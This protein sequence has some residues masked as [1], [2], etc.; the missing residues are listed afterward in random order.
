MAQDPEVDE[1]GIPVMKQPKPKQPKQEVDEFGIPV[2]KQPKQEVDEFGIPL[3][4]KG[5]GSSFIKSDSDGQFIL[6]EKST[7]GNSWFID[8][9][10][11]KEKPEFKEKESPVKFTPAFR[12]RIPERDATSVKKSIDLAEGDITTTPE[13]KMRR[14]AIQRADKANKAIQNNTK[15]ELDRKNVKYKVGDATYEKKKQELQKKYES[16]DLKVILGYDGEPQLARELTYAEEGLRGLDSFFNSVA[17]LFGTNKHKSTRSM[18]EDELINYYNENREKRER[19]GYTYSSQVGSA[20]QSVIAIAPYMFL[21]RGLGNI[22]R[23]SGTAL[24]SRIISNPLLRTGS[25]AEIGE[26]V[27]AGAG[28]SYLF[29]KSAGDAEREKRYNE[30]VDE[31]TAAGRTDLDNIY[32]EAI[33]KAKIQAED[34]EVIAAGTGLLQSIPMNNILKSTDF[35][36]NKKNFGRILLSEI[37]TVNRDAPLQ[38]GSMA[39]QN[40]LTEKSAES[41]GYEA[42]PLG[43]AITGTIDGLIFHYG[44]NAIAKGLPMTK[45]GISYAKEWFKD[46]PTLELNDMAKELEATGEIPKGSADNFV[47]SIEEYKAASEFV[48]EGVKERP[49]FVGKIVKINKLQEQQSKIN[50]ELFPQEH[51]AIQNEIDA[52][53]KDL[54]IMSKSENPIEHETNDLTGKP[55][56]SVIK[57]EEVTKPNVVEPTPS[58]KPMGEG[59]EQ[60][61]SDVNEENTKVGDIV[62]HN[63]K[64]VKIVEFRDS[65]KGGREAIIE[66][67]Q[68][69][70][71]EIHKQAIDILRNRYKEF[72]NTDE[73]VIS[74]HR[75]DYLNQISDISHS[76]SNASKR[77][78]VNFD[79]LSKSQPTETKDTVAPQKT[80]KGEG[81]VSKPNVVEK[82]AQGELETA[83]NIGVSENAFNSFKEKNPNKLIG[84]KNEDGSIAVATENGDI[85]FKDEVKANNYAYK[86]GKD[87]IGIIEKND[88]SKQPQPSITEETKLIAEQPPIE[89]PKDNKYLYSSNENKRVSGLMSHIQE[90]TEIPQEVK[91]KFKE[92]GI[93]YNV[94][95]EKNAQLVAKELIKTLG[96]DDALQV[97]RGEDM[98][99]SVRSAIYAE[100]INDAW[101]REQQAIKSGDEN[102]RL[103]AAAE[104]ASISREWDKKLTAGGQF[105][106]YAKQFYKTSPLGF[107]LK[108]NAET[109]AKFEDFLKGK[110]K[111]YREIFNELKKTDEGSQIIKEELEKLRK[112][113]RISERKSKREKVH[114]TIDDTMAKWA[115]KLTAKGTEGAQKQG[116]GIEQVFKFAGDAMKKAYD[117]G[118]SVAKVVQDAIDYISK[119][120]G[121]KEWDSEVFRQE[122]E[123]KLAGNKERS[124]EEILQSRK[125]E[126]ERRIREQDFSAEKYKEKKTLTEKEKAAKDELEKVKKQYN[127]VKKESKEYKEKKAKQYLE[128]VR[129]RLK[130]MTDAQ[131]EEFIK[132][133]S[134]KLIENKGLEYP[135]FKKILADVMGYKELSEAQVKRAEELVDNINNLDAVEQNMIK[136]PSQK[137]IS[138]FENARK[139]AL[140]SQLELYNMT[141]SKTDVVSTFKSLIT[142]SLLGGQTLITNFIQNPIFQATVRFPKA[143]VKNI[144]DLGYYGVSNMLNKFRGAKTLD[145]TPDLFLAQKGYWKMAGKGA[146]L[147]WFNFL[148]GT[149][150]KD[151]FGKNQYQTTL[152]PKQAAKE[153]ELY[154]KGELALTNAEVFDRYLRKAYFSRQADFILRGMQL[155]D[156]PPRWG[157]EGFT[158]YKIAVKELKLDNPDE[159]D[160]FMASPEKYAQKV[161][162]KQGKSVEQANELAAEI[163]ERIIFEGEK[164]V[165]Q[166]ENLLSKASEFIE[167]GL[168]QSK[169]D[170]GGVK[171]AKGIASVG[172]T[173]TFPFVKIP[174]N[175]YWSSFKIAMPE[176]AFAQSA[177]QFKKAISERKAGNDATANRYFSRAK[178]N[179]AHGIVGLGI[180]LA[181]AS[182]VANGFVRAENDEDTKKREREGERTFGK[183]NQLNLGRLMGGNDYWVDLKWLGPLGVVLNVK[184]RMNDDKLKKQWEGDNE[185]ETFMQN[186]T[187]RLEYSGVAALNNLVFEQGANMV[188]ALKGG[189]NAVKYWTVNTMNTVGN[190]FTGATYTALSKALLPEQARLKGENTIEEII[191]NQ[192][193]RNV[194]L[195]EG[196]NL[197]KQGSG[198]PPSRISIWG[199]PIKNDRSVTGVLSNMLGFEKGN[200]EIFGAILYEDAKRTGSNKFFPTVEDNKIEVNGEQVKLNQNEKDDLDKFIGNA[201]KTLI[202]GLVYDQVYQYGNKKYSEMNDKQKEYVV[203]LTYK[204]AKKIGLN[205]FVE[206][207]PKYK[208][209]IID[210]QKEIDKEMK[211]LNDELYELQL[212]PK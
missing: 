130:D 211:Q 188:N 107:V 90:A 201:R 37:N 177:Y 10:N 45:A 174:A 67:P 126:L 28:L 148:K 65:R 97:A 185:Q 146:S 206:V 102:A 51:R 167:Q 110:E 141:S 43:G 96:K 38:A 180:N 184:A 125:E 66:L 5:G 142:G 73:D 112:E 162:L 58:S 13:E 103:D 123:N 140:E 61:G 35:N 189:D 4:K 21:S 212:P 118:E 11:I 208:S 80:G 1:F 47:K 171:L 198:N 16:G 144:I 155:G 176:V 187:D 115:K 134:K 15:F 166:E 55:L 197:Y 114:K 2:M 81:E 85:S 71:D 14:R 56:I 105:T 78:N 164:A 94:A 77:V 202:K 158:A 76:D 190:I 137:T 169:S 20:I 42:D 33:R 53:M 138:E 57:P 95:N 139:R 175:L 99:P 25:Y 87:G 50:P 3:K 104:W 39:L 122:W 52:E 182:L 183:Q 113:E 191:N 32:K 9:T 195:R 36:Q 8:P 68:L 124:Y 151:Y 133:I 92:E 54:K 135:E 109:N 82:V 172:K 100:T 136:N 120:L 62:Y 108:A 88:L 145:M 93:E 173:L 64:A 59:G 193:Q 74:N 44:V 168:R 63:G 84:V 161:F 29:A 150:N 34:A 156:N 12:Y 49:S 91:N 163:K 48:P 129:N 154:K 209:E 40:Y 27:S 116:V 79:E 159:I 17:D 131:K 69:T 199:E 70:K 132:R 106:S 157:A 210:I 117:A 127:E 186:F 194:L 31:Q 6:Q 30:Y 23:A 128:S 147:G 179:I 205:Q 98:H 207:Y 181:A 19:E 178:D 101:A 111:N 170:R 41:K 121:T 119:E 60:G 7:I 204:N 26:N 160:A 153:L 196:L 24:E 72:D 22:G 192:K 75:G 203:D 46:V 149:E 86:S 83:K 152:S 89:P 143:I 18:D 200:G 165:F